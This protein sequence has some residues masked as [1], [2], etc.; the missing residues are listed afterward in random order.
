MFALSVKMQR[1]LSALHII[2]QWSHGIAIVVASCGC[3][4]SV[5]PVPESNPQSL[6]DVIVGTEPASDMVQ[7]AG[8]TQILVEAAQRLGI[9][10]VHFNGTT[11]E[12]LLPEITGSGAAVFDFDN[13]GDLD[14]YLVQGAL[15][16]TENIGEGA[17]VWTGDRPP[18]DRLY[19]NE[20]I[21]T[22]ALAFTDVTDAS[23]IVSEGYGMGVACGDVNNDGWIDLYVT[24]LGRNLML[25][26]NGNGT[27]QDVTTPVEA[28]DQWSTSAAFVDYDNDGWLDL[29]VVNYADFSIDMK[30]RCFSKTSARDYCGPD[31]YDA[32][33]DQLLHN[34]GDGS[35]E[36]VTADSGIKNVKAAGLG[37]VCADFNDDGWTDIYVAN[38]G[39]ANQLWINQA[40]SGKFI[41]DALLAGAALNRM[42]QAEAGMGVDAGDV[43]GDGDLDLF[44]VHLEGESNT[45]YVKSANGL[46][47]DR[48][49][50]FGLHAPSLNRTGFGTGFVDYD[51]DGWLDVLVLNGAVRIIENLARKGDAYPLHQANQLFHNRGG[52]AF[53]EV[54]DQ[55]GEAM[56]LSEVSR[57]AAF[58]DLDN[59]GDTDIVGMNNNGRTRVL[60]NQIGNQQRWVGL[61]VLD[62]SGTKDAS[63]AMAEI[64]C[65]DGRKITRRVAADGGYCSSQDPR[66]LVGLAKNTDPVAVRIRWPNGHI[67]Q[68]QGLRTNC[69]WTLQPEKMP[70]ELGIR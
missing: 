3:S 42:G 50:E 46:F 4:P 32:V 19:R 67:Q 70:R 5:Q 36:D 14:V 1:V 38:D 63:H 55:A 6:A 43:D 47:D 16:K 2:R 54:T 40:G 33:S 23:G 9:D 10:F 69:Y 60:L 39:D 21:E 59:D 51:N 11:G 34:L 52:R 45:L 44:M 26:N 35:F 17:A 7:D 48:T 66:V 25:R 31:S 22:G 12:Y 8:S 49:I 18:R 56:Q 37:V 20:L 62:A 65:S 61:R 30:R 64:T 57:G 28:G 68:W 13:D 27:F 15:L 53:D 58:G 24:N 41:D 29:Y